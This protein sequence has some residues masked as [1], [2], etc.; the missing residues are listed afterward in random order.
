MTLFLILVLLFF[1]P[2]LSLA[3]EPKKQESLPPVVVTA[4]RTETPEEQATTS[5]TVITDEEIRQQQAES[6]LEVLRN[7]PGL[8]VV[9][10]GSRGNTA[11]VFIRG[12]ESDHVLVLIDGVEVNSPTTGGFDFA[13]LTTESIERIEVLRGAGGTLYGSQAIGGVIQII[14]KAG[15]GRPELSLSAEGGN[16]R[17]DRQATTLRGGGERLGYAFS[18][19]RLETSG[20]R[21]QNDDYRNLATSGRLDFRPTEDTALRGIFHF[22]KTDLGLFNSNNFIA[23]MG[24]ANARQNL[25]D[26]LFRL[27]WEQTLLRGWD[28]RL[29]GSLF[30]E[31]QKFSD[32]PEPGS[33]DVRTR[34]R[35]RQRILTGDFQTNYRWREWSITTFGIEY[36]NRGAT[37]STVSRTTIREDQGNVAYYLQE[38]LRFF[39]E[40]L[41]LV[42]GVRLDDHQAFGTELSPSFSAAY[43][44]KE[45]GTKFKFGYAEGFKAPSLNELFFPNFGNPDLGPEKSWEINAGAEQKLLERLQVGLTYFHRE[46]E[47]L[48]AAVFNPALGRFEAQ[49][50]SQVR[51]DG[52][53]LFGDVNVA[54]GL[55]LRANYTFLE[56]DTSR[57]RLLR[58]PRHR[59]NFLINYQE[60]PFHINLNVN[61]VGRRD[62]VNVT[63]GADVKEAGYVKVDLAS[64]YQ[65]PLKL[66]GVE[67][68]SLY[69]KIENLFNKKYQ[70]ADG[71]R[72]RP[73]NFLI[74]I[75]AVFSNR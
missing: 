33:F 16:G 15:K 7:V 64:S 14:T 75:R 71:F 38:Q 11:S 31:H 21:R 55:S 37:V 30:K 28:Y 47:D 17:T 12:S 23:G 67:S 49:N 54:R 41:F 60:E 58:R 36:K 32:D 63:S 4:T 66:T 68:L 10:T 45:T 18:A 25:T 72:A 19:S 53:E 59:G 48:I 2:G 13:H 22:R 42:G 3:A 5:I 35:F 29:S 44:L 50:V 1:P 40:R 57:G 62:D 69:G 6:V 74:G 9:Q 27:D 56:N 51:V 8:D 52:I 39:E 65:L 24:D 34:N 61:V 26:Y 43:H 70:E 46:V 73:L 20:F